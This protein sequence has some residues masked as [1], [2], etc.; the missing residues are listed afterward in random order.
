MTQD[1][2]YLLVPASPGQVWEVITHDGWLA[3]RVELDLAPGGPARFSDPHEI[4]TGWVEEAQAPRPDGEGRLVFWWG[5]EGEP[6]TRVELTLAPEGEDSTRLRV[7]ESR[8]LEVLDLVGLPVPDP[9]ASSHGPAVLALAC[10][11]R[12]RG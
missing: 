1:D 8:P 4:R 9:G 5:P 11:G 7:A 3:E 12:R 6:A 10:P 2:R